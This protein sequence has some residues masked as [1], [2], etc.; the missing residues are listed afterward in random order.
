[1]PFRP[2]GAGIRAGSKRA[3]MGHTAGGYTGFDADDITKAKGHYL[4]AIVKLNMRLWNDIVDEDVLELFDYMDE[5][6]DGTMSNREFTSL[7][8]NSLQPPL[9]ET[10]LDA[11]FKSI[12]HS[13]DGF[14]HYEDLKKAIS[15]GELR[16]AL[17]RV[18][19]AKQQEELAKGEVRKRG[20][21][22][23]RDLAVNRL[24][25][26]VA[27]D[28]ALFTL[29]VTLIF[30][31]VFIGVVISHLQVKAR[32]ELQQGMEDWVDGY[33]GPDY[34][35]PYLA[36]HVGNYEQWMT[37]LDLSGLSLVFHACTGPA[38]IAAG[39]EVRCEVAPRSFLVGD[40]K[41]IKTLVDGDQVEEWM[42]HSPEAQEHLALQ[43]TDYLGAAKK[44]L[45]ALWSQDWVPLSADDRDMIAKMEM[46]FITYSESF[47]AFVLTS[48]YLVV[49]SQGTVI[50]ETTSRAVV[51]NPY[52]NPSLWIFGGIYVAMLI[53]SS[54]GE[55]KQVWRRGCQG[56]WECH[57]TGRFNRWLPSKDGMM[58]GIDLCGFVVGYGNIL[59][60]VFFMLIITGSEV[61]DMLHDSE[62]GGGALGGKFHLVAD[63]MNVDIAAVE[64]LETSLR[65]ASSSYYYMQL[66]MGLNVISIISK[67]FKAFG[68]NAR[69][70]LVSNTMIRA[71]E[72]LFHF[73]VVFGSIL[74]GFAL[75]GHILFGEDIGEFRDFSI[76]VNTACESLLGDF[77]WYS[78]RAMSHK[79]MGSGLPFAAV[80]A[81]FYI[82]MVF[83][84]LVMMNMLLAIVMDHYMNLLGEVKSSDEAPALW[85]Q[86]ARMY[87]R[88]KH[89]KGWLKEESLL[90]E[91][92]EL[93]HH[94]ET[95][96][97][98]KSLKNAFA[99]M[100]EA[101]VESLMSTWKTEA[102]KHDKTIKPADDEVHNMVKENNRNLNDI[103]DQL[104]IV[105]H[106][107]CR[108]NERIDALERALG[109]VDGSPDTSPDRKSLQ[110]N[111]VQSGNLMDTSTSIQT[112][113]K[114]VT[115][116]EDFERLVGDL[117]VVVGQLQERE[118]RIAEK[119]NQ[120]EMAQSKAMQMPTRQLPSADEPFTCCR[121]SR[122]SA[123]ESRLLVVPQQ[124]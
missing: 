104:R 40:V 55:I 37:W 76:S 16:D 43:P 59:Q 95:E 87:T 58:N 102:K 122:S 110:K 12:N 80:A 20:P 113:S 32:F 74:I 22:V 2:V 35:G 36:E 116:P 30:I 68:A 79:E 17:K 9:S 107:S 117:R 105:T 82:Y 23:S 44:R 10:D 124:R 11:I 63:A 50:V 92:V 69:L 28:D 60:W 29:P 41:I 53:W 48:A 91:L 99:E 111:G 109:V 73:G 34:T 77:D 14:M 85:T 38:A 42:L 66:A 97:T 89:Q 106:S 49:K 4:S 57:G 31:A 1:M 19:H 54:F 46:Y 100:S 39:M 94:P 83:V 119:T 81:W 118:R 72:D 120:Y 88:Y 45:A 114:H 3:H 101:Q 78:T 52:S 71:S 61:R 21:P 18:H 26:R 6:G 112:Q 96:V 121:P 84:V 98:P 86:G 15:A 24:E 62:E 123:P 27:R 8:T 103:T 56:Y 33:A 67:L 51:I 108:S 47:E 5:N 64:R 65:G 75:T 70:Q 115:P 93:G 13:R 90:H 25:W 7:L